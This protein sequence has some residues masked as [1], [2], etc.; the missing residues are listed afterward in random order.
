MAAF[1]RHLDR[2]G[3]DHVEDVAV[4]ALA[5]ED[6]AGRHLD[7]GECPR[8]RLERRLGQQR[9][10]RHL[11]QELELRRREGGEVDPAQSR[12]PEQYEAAHP[13]AHHDEAPAKADRPDQDRHQQCPDAIP[14]MTALSIAPNTRAITASGVTRCRIV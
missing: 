5:N 14:P 2:A 13:G 11:A 4:V 9:E 3:L 12:H 7:A 8:K 1:L 6:V 10:Q